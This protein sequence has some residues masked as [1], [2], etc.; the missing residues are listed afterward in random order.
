MREEYW[1]Y[2]FWLV[3][4]A[5]WVLGFVYGK[6]SGNEGGIFSDIGQA[7]SVPHP[8]QL[9]LWQ[10]ILYLTLTVVASFVLSQLFFGV[11]AAVFLFARGISDSRL[12]TSLETMVTNWKLTSVPPS[13]IWTALFIMLILVVNMPLCLWAAQLGTRRSRQMLYRLRGKPTKPETNA[14]PISNILIIITVSLAVGL[15]ATFAVANI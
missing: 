6:W 5:S 8:S 14:E 10:P 9:E 12:V 15:L 3:V 2:G 11:G 7:I 4:V 13:E 1:H